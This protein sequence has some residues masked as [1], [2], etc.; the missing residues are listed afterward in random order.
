[1]GGADR[2]GSGA[3][4]NRKRRP[5]RRRGGRPARVDRSQSVARDARAQRTGALPRPVHQRPHLCASR[6]GDRRGPAWRIHRRRGHPRRGDR[7][8]RHRICPGGAG[9]ARSRRNP[10]DDHAERLGHPRRPSGDRRCRVAGSRRRRPAR[11]RRPDAGRCP[12]DQGSQP[13][14]RGGHSYRRVGPGRQGNRS[15]SRLGG[16][17]RPHVDGLFGNAGRCRS[18]GRRRG[19]D[20]RLHGTRK[21]QQASRHGRV[22]DNAAGQADGPVR[23]A[24]DRRHSRRRRGRLRFRGSRPLATR[25]RM[26]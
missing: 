26:R 24:A 22:A 6:F 5:L 8:R 20:R 9:G 7:Q 10:G 12:A 16:V 17:R 1:M 25:L 3:T 18:G 19:R 14:G 15:G 13:E 4:C 2:R 23:Q 21:D 11:G